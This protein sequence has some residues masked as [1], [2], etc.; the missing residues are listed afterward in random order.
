MSTASVGTTSGS[1]IN[2]SGLASG[3]DTS[4]IISALLA[5]EKL[6][7]THLTSQ[8]EKLSGQQTILQKLQANLQQLGFAVAEF[9]RPSLFETAQVANSSEPQRIGATVSAGAGVGGY[10]LE[11]TQLANSAQRTY[12][13][14]SPTAEDTITI[15]GREYKLKEGA[16]AAE[17]A[18]KINSDGKGGVY[19]AVTNSETIVLSSRTSGANGG[20]FIKVSD[21]GG[22]LTEKAGTAKEGR[23]AEYTVDGVAGSS[24]SNVVTSAIPGVTLT[25][26]ALTSAGAVTIA[27]QAPTVSTTAIETEL[28]SFVTLY[29]KTVEEIQTQL[30]TKPLSNPQNA[31]ELATGS[32]FGD[33]DLTDLL[34]RMRQTMYEPIAG[35]TGEMTSPSAIGIST[36]TP[37]G[38]SSQTSLSGLLKLNA[39]TLTNALQSNPEGVKTMLQKWSLGLQ[40]TI[41]QT[42]EPGGSLETRANGDGEQIRS[43]KT[44]IATMNEMLAIRQKSLQQTYANLE[45]AISRNS[46]QGQWLASQ[47]EQL[48]KSGI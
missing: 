29:N 35:L 48:T 3:L 38:T 46:S 39:A 44:R 8:Q 26:N 41:N 27:V 11:V 16:T 40:S 30:T 42:A 12:A 36:G 9:S 43:L 5:V 23:N 34:S 13:F 17:L 2:I 6:P 32:L 20:E 21:P 19:A 37:T 45:A 33:S 18:G 31:T 22:T 47:A 1:P 4:S 15:E 24:T 14:T 28:Q 25:F 7:I 10:Q